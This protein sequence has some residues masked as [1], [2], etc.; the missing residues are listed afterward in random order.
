[1]HDQTLRRH[2]VR[3][4]HN[5]GLATPTTALAMPSHADASGDRKAAVE[6]IASV[7]GAASVA[8]ANNI[9][10]GDADDGD[11]GMGDRVDQPRMQGTRL[12]RV[13]AVYPLKGPAVT[14]RLVL[15]AMEEALLT[16]VQTEYSPHIQV[17]DLVDHH[18]ERRHLD[19]LYARD[20][21]L[22]WLNDEVINFYMALIEARAGNK[23]VCCFSTFFYQRLMP[24]EA[25]PSSYRF[26]Q[27]KRWMPKDLKSR[28]LQSIFQFSQLFL[29]LHVDGTHWVLVVVLCRD[30]KFWYYDSLSD[31]GSVL[32]AVATQRL[33]TVLLYLRDTFEQETGSR[34]GFCLADWTFEAYDGPRQRNVVDCG[35][36]ILEVA[37][38]LSC[39]RRPV[40]ATADLSALRKRV[41]LEILDLR[42]H[43]IVAPRHADSVP[44]VPVATVA[45]APA[46][47]AT[48]TTK[49]SIESVLKMRMDRDGSRQFFIQW[50]G[51]GPVW[52]SWVSGRMYQ[53]FV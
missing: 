4:A 39:G 17:A 2:N 42:L 15:T 28:G 12:A 11:D 3:W 26:S 53:L 22:M 30:K 24:V 18:V 51:C 13:V 32:S 36:Y 49:I 33:E 41:I 29:P 52:N 7:T 20:P 1:M 10:V 31:S 48:A 46:A 19:C 38:A 25:S 47:V 44:C 43:S 16:A 45:A 6:S 35:I 9:A 8:R 50:R 23:Q 40:I 34:V 27:V 37:A 5:D 14:D 21:L